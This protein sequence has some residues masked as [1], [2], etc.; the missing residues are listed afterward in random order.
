MSIRRYFLFIGATA[1]TTLAVAQGISLDSMRSTWVDTIRPARERVPHLAAWLGSDSTLTIQ[2]AVRMV[3]GDH[4]DASSTAYVRQLG[5]ATLAQSATYGRNRR[6]TEAIAASKEALR[7]AEQSGFAAAIALAHGYLGRQYAQV[8]AQAEAVKHQLLAL[9]GYEQMKDTL[10]QVSCN[11][12]LAFAYSTQGIN[13]RALDFYKRNFALMRHRSPKDEVDVMMRMADLYKDMDDQP[14][15]MAWLDSAARVVQMDGEADPERLLN[16]TRGGFLKDNGDCAGALAEFRITL[17]AIDAE[18]FNPAGKS[19]IRSQMAQ[20]YNCANDFR[21]AV[22]WATAGLAIAEEHHLRKEELDNLYPLAIA[23]EGVGNTRDGLRYY[24]RYHALLDSVSNADMARGLSDAALK[25][26][27][28]KKQLADSLVAEQHQ[29]EA[30]L[31]ITRERGNRNI[32]LV[33]GLFAVVLA[34]VSHRQRKQTQK[35]LKRSD[36][37]LLNILP[38]EVAEELKEK[39]RA[40]AK[41]FANVTILFTDFKGFTEASERMSPQELVEELNT[42]FKAFD[43]IITV[44]GIEKIK[45]I[46]DAYMCVGGLPDPASSTPADVVHAALEM[47][48]FMKARKT[49]R[50]VQGKPSFEMRVG[51]HSG[52][53]VAGI[54]GVKKFQY[55]IW[56][57]TVNTASRMESSGEVG[58]VNVSGATY[59]LVRE[60]AGSLFDFTP[61]GKVQTKGKGELEMWFVDARY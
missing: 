45:T 49:E 11:S 22:Q 58:K 34:T 25:L 9:Q 44:R 61:R 21:A 28:A 13:D 14:T 38:E 1:C 29:H 51:I 55:D 19:W 35:A 46:G 32:L 43:A 39:G 42:C 20:A 50:D 59:A 15:A 56:G 3:V 33:V 16:W 47:Q 26:D 52:P 5:L 60:Q 18:P 6:F 54:V 40:E 48:A 57:D 4:M 10:G 37:L 41:H 17:S 8:G 2:Q 53:V 23:Y 24:K 36:E 12:D 31:V 27:F 30:D 7:M